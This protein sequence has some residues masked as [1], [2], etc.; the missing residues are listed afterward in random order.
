MS[1][2]VSGV[3]ILNTETNTQQCINYKCHANKIPLY[4][5]LLNFFDRHYNYTHLTKTIIKD[6]AT[7]EERMMKLFSWTRQS[8][9]DMPEGFPVIDDHV[10]HIIVRGYGSSEQLQDVFTTLCNYIGLSAFFD[11]IFT[12]MRRN[13]K[14]VS[15]VCIDKKWLVFDA[16]EG[17]YFK[18]SEN[19]LA[20]IDELIDGDWHAVG[21]T[22]KIQSADMYKGYFEYLNQIDYG[23]SIFSRSAIQS[24]LRRLM[25]WLKEILYKSKK[26]C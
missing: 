22:G 10:W 5:K 7:D 13:K 8:I 16:Y 26:T 15:F 14:I 4:L 23:R 3:L 12:P 20:G 11:A 6:A 1:I 18:N 24:P 21:I 2:I 25:F 9:K 19:Q 17:V